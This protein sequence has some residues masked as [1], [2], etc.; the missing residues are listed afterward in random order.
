[1][2]IFIPDRFYD[3][4]IFQ[5][6]D[7]LDEKRKMPDTEFS[8][9]I[10]KRR[11]DDQKLWAQF[12]PR[13]FETLM[14]CMI[15]ELGVKAISDIS[16]FFREQVGGLFNSSYVV[17][18]LKEKSRVDELGYILFEPQNYKWL[19]LLHLHS[20]FYLKKW[21]EKDMDMAKLYI[22]YKVADCRGEDT[23]K[24][25]KKLTMHFK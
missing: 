8:I 20:D 1:M 15:K 11:P 12:L 7:I 24:H 25:L 6:E 4:N 17:P 21:F 5:I 2:Y 9:D 10:D 18:D 19:T 14:E 3:Q 22:Q 13:D 16:G 23:S